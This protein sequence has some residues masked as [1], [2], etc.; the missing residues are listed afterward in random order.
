[1]KYKLKEIRPKVFLVS[2]QDNYDLAML[3]LRYQEYYESPNV[4]FRRKSFTI[5]DF[6]EWYSKTLSEHKSFTY[7]DDWIGFNFDR[8]VLDDF[9]EEYS[10]NQIQI[11]D[12]N[13]YDD[14]MQTIY[15]RCLDKVD[16]VFKHKNKFYVIG[17]NNINIIKHELS[18]AFFYL[19]PEYKKEST[20]LVKQL[21]SKIKLKFNSVLKNRGYTKS[22]FVDEVVAYCST[23]IP[24]TFKIPFQ[25]KDLQPFIKLFNE[26]YNQ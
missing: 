13:K 6:M 10:K 15:N 11:K 5:I 4:K 19:R 2:C 16:D 22:V 21:N 23:G 1:M 12:R 26:Y 18:H 8:S 17:G 3:F 7:T 14:A 25:N 9:Y 20:E 24:E